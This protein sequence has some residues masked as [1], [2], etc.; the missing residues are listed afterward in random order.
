MVE[1]REMIDADVFLMKSEHIRMLFCDM[2]C[3]VAVIIFAV[4]IL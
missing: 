2:E 4:V 3:I 1:F